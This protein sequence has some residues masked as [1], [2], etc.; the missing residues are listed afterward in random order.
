MILILLHT[1]KERN[2]FLQLWIKL[3]KMIVDL[4]NT[5]F[6]GEKWEVSPE[7]NVNQLI[8]RQYDVFVSTAL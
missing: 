8:G 5:T 1:T 7:K 6:M 3:K 2:S 4:L